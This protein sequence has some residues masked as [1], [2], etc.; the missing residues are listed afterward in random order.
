VDL[1]DEQVEQVLRTGQPIR[2]IVVRAPASGVVLVRN[3]FPNQKV[4]PDSDLYTIADLSRVWVL[5]DVFESDVPNVTLG[6][7]PGSRYPP[8][9]RRR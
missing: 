9:D 3:A 4:T 2:D 1:G 6:T 8:C 7:R 5:A